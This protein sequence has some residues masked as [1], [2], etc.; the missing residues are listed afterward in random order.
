VGTEEGENELTLVAGMVTFN[1]Q[2]ALYFAVHRNLF[3]SVCPRILT[4]CANCLSDSCSAIQT[5]YLDQ[6]TNQK[7]PSA[8]CSVSVTLATGN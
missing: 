7:Y 4:F 2:Q 6:P 3:G 5:V 1:K 8:E